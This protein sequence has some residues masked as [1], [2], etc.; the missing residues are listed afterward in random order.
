MENILTLRNALLLYKTLKNE[1]IREVAICLD[2][3][4]HF[5]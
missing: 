1:R 4:D 2:G 3:M 5:I